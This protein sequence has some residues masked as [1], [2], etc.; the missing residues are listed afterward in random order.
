M[1]INSPDLRIL[2]MMVVRSGK[3]NQ[4]VDLQRDHAKVGPGPCLR[5]TGF[6][7]QLDIDSL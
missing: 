2:L 5:N 3:I 4:I 7:M 1:Q 6:T